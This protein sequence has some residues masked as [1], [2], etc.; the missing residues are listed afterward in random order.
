MFTLNRPTAATLR[1]YLRRQRHERPTGGGP[2]RDGALITPAGSLVVH[3]RTRIG[4]GV[5]DYARACDALRTWEMFHNGW[6]TV[7]PP[8]E[9]QRVDATIA[10]VARASG[11]WCLC[12]CRVV[13]LFEEYDPGVSRS[14]VVLA[15]L[16]GHVLRGAE[17]FVVEY[18]P[19]DGS[20]WFEI[21][22]YSCP[23]SWVW[24]LV[25][26]LIRRSQRRFVA[27]AAGAMRRAIALA[28]AGV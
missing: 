13:R 1:A 17:Q 23:K 4:S 19:S 15:T 22:S 20:V 6:S 12:A 28:E 25:R 16:P 14:G 26:P 3:S 9:P 18:H 10:I 8:D 24:G 2:G 11:V 5:D 7:V 27:D 21:R